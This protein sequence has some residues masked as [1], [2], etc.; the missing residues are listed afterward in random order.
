MG[1]LGN[2]QIRLGVVMICCLLLLGLLSWW[3]LPTETTGI[4]LNYK[5]APPQLGYLFG[6][7]HYGRNILGLVML[8][9][10]SSLLI[11][12]GGVSLGLLG[13]VSLGLFSASYTDW[14]GWSG[15]RISDFLFA[16]PALI[17]ALLL[18]A[19]FGPGADKAVIAIGLFTIPVF[20]RV[21]HNAA[22]PLWS[23]DFIL[24]ARLAGASQTSILF[25]HILPNIAPLIGVQISL[26]SGLAIVIESG[27]GYLGLGVQPP[28]T[29]WGR[30][31]AEAQ[32]YLFIAPWQIIFPALCIF[33]GVLGF[34]LIGDGWRDRLDRR[35]L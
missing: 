27:L 33:G 24:A 17:T 30:M 12:L 28:M 11:A 18:S 7:D 23:R 32:P 4:F 34:Q 6:R 2:W 14:R 25:K 29:S 22:W 26:Q 21:T 19:A 16:F 5:L 9:A 20:A 1:N 35:S 15:K 13:G 31:L 8:G 10:Q 3:W